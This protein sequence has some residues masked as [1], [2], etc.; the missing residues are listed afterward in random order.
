MLEEYEEFGDEELRVVCFEVKKNFIGVFLGISLGI[1]L[2]NIRFFI[3]QFIDYWLLE[4]IG[5]VEYKVMGILVMR[6]CYFIYGM[7]DC[8]L[9]DSFYYVFV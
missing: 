1:G 4:G 9:Y 5:L 3:I 8:E 7:Q 2:Q 6:E